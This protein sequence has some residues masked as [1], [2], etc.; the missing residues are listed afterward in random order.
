MSS[1]QNGAAQAAENANPASQFSEGLFFH[2]IVSSYVDAPRFLRRDWLEQDLQRR[3]DEPGCRFV[4]LTGEPGGGK[5]GFIAQLAAAHHD[6]PVYFIRRDQRRSLGEASAKSFLLRIGFQMAA[7]FPRAF[8][9][10]Q[11]RV[12]IEQ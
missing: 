7:L 6:W 2:R 3:L 11:I 9:L 1:G 10:E 4:L 5:S 8:D 12:D